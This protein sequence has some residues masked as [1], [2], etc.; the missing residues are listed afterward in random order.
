MMAA[1]VMAGFMASLGEP[2]AAGVAFDFE[3]LAGGTDVTNQFPEASFSSNPGYAA[4]VFAAKPGSYGTSGTNLITTAES[5]GGFDFVHDL[6]VDFTDPVDDLTFLVAADHNGGVIGQ[7][8]VFQNATLAGSM[9][10]IG[11]ADATTP[12][13][14]DLSGYDG[15][16]RIEITKVSDSFGLLYDDF[17]FE[18]AAS[19]GLDDPV[20]YQK[21]DF[22]P[23]PDF[24]Q[25]PDF[26]E[27]PDYEPSYDN[28]TVTQVP[29]PAGLALFAFG[30]AGLGLMR[31]RRLA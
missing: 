6:F 25:K 28:G 23:K 8:T 27:E 26:D 1:A 2:A 22:D 12:F 4:R 11:D 29:E 30:L 10:I 24:D 14:A 18:V 7:I 16:T 15:I 20:T 19:E 5:S 21:P 3:S 17:Y 31:R 9:K 13:L